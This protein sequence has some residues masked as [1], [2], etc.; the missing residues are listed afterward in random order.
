MPRVGE[1][2]SRSRYPSTGYESD[3]SVEILDDPCAYTTLEDD[4]ISQN[5]SAQDLTLTFADHDT[6][7][8][9]YHQ[10]TQHAWDHIDGTDL[11]FGT[12]P[13]RKQ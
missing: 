13:Q 3:D 1:S 6:L 10:P 2:S 4:E 8:N 9:A 12:H 7:L 5:P 11:R